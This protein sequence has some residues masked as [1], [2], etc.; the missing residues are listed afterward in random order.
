MNE[1]T[2]DNGMKEYTPEEV[3]EHS[4]IQTQITADYQADKTTEKSWE[5]IRD[6]CDSGGVLDERCNIVA[7]SL[8]TG[9]LDFVSKRLKCGCLMIERDLLDELN[10][11]IG[12]REVI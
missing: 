5:V 3:M 7:A 11:D 10:W 8:G 9:K 1:S 12:P 6:E 2:E 4:L